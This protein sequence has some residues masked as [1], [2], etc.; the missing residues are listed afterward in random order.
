M[1]SR[2]TSSTPGI[3]LPGTGSLERP[4]ADA[5][6]PRALIVSERHHGMRADAFLALRLTR[7]TR[8]RAR[9][10]VAAGG[11]RRGGRPLKPAS[12]VRRGESVTLARR[13]LDELPPQAP[14]AVLSDRDGL[15]VIDKPA[16]VVVHPTARYWRSALTQLL[17]AAGPDDDFAPRPCHRLDR[18]TSGVLLLARTAEI[19]RAVK[20][21]FRRNAVHKSYLA[22]VDGRAEEEFVVD[23]P[24]AIGHGAIKMRMAPTPGA[25]PALTRFRRLLALGERSLVLAE[26]AHGRTHQIRAHLALAGHPIVGDKIYGSQGESWFLRHAV[27]GERTAP[28]AELAWPRQCLHAWRVELPAGVDLETRCFSAPWPGDLPPLPCDLESLTGQPTA[29]AAPAG[30]RSR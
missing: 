12:R 19:E 24:L 2:N 10:I 13:A 6:P 9:A 14:I 22:L 4:G 1:T 21:A 28:V 11:L 17:A 26:P 18:E 23:A 15:L 16:H 20:A 5:P 8:N 7:L 27:G 30:S 29:S 25:P 3:E